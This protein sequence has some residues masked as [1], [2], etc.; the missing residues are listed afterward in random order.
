MEN[1]KE[2]ELIKQA[3]RTYKRIYANMEKQQQREMQSL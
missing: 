1:I 3:K 2:L